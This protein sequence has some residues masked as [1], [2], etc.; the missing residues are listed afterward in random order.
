MNQTEYAVHR[1]V[2][3]SYISRLVKL[4]KIPRDRNGKI[5]PTVAD[6]ALAGMADPGKASVVAYHAAKRDRSAEYPSDVPDEPPKPAETPIGDLVDQAETFSEAKRRD[7][8]AAADLREME[9]DRI[10]GDLVERRAYAKGCI[11]A[12]SAL[13]K[14]LDGM[15]HRLAP[16]VAGEPGITKCRELIAA[17][18]FRA[19]DVFADTLEALAADPRNG[20]KQ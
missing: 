19:R 2:S 7:A 10:K 11:D 13:G 20:T 12:A 3:S 16:L 1:Q 15:I 17:E 4:G 5:D 8:E 14:E 6:A 18:V 9:R